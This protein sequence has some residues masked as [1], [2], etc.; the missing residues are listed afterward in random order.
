M[1]VYNTEDLQNILEIS[2]RQARAL[3][4][5][6]GFPSIKIGNQYRISEDNLMKWLEN[7]REIKLDY[8]KL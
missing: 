5:T 2:D 3:M 1:E 4:R 6:E 8:S 7:T